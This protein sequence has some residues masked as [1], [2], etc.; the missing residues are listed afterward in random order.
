MRSYAVVSLRDNQQFL[1]LKIPGRINNPD[2]MMGVTI[3]F[4][5][6]RIAQ[7]NTLSRHCGTQ[8]RGMGAALVPTLIQRPN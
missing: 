6:S 1:V 4:L 5:I 3:Y 7:L 2:F 8:T